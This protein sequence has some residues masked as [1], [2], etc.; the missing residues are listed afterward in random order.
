MVDASLI[1]QVKAGNLSAFERLVRST[2]QKGLNI[3]YGILH[4]P[5]DA[6][7]VLQ[8]AYLEVYHSIRDIKTSEAFQSWF[9]KIITHLAFRQSRKKGRFKTIPLDEAAH[10]ES[11]MDDLEQV[12]LKGEE[13][14]A[15]LKALKDLP[16]EYRAALILREWEGYSY[17]EIGEVL[18]IPLGTVKSRIFSARRILTIKLREGGMTDGRG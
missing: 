13:H 18:D 6:E 5:F 12:F 8:E 15:L 11:G 2:Q 1:E 4:D 17:Q 10:Y 9:A 14:E 16:D 7:E 3:A